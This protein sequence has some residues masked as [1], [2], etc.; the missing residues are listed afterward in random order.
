MA[1]RGLD[2]G[3][4]FK[5]N[6]QSALNIANPSQSNLQASPQAQAQIQKLIAQVQSGVPIQQIAAN[7]ASAIASALAPSATN[8]VNGLNNGTTVDPSQVQAKITDLITNALAPPGNSPPGTPAQQVAALVMKVQNWLNDIAGGA[9]QGT[10]QQSEFSEQLLDALTAKD[11]PAQ[12]NPTQSSSATAAAFART[13]LDSVAS[14]LQSG[15]AQ[16][17][18][19]LPTATGTPGRPGGPVA[20]GTPG[21]K[22]PSANGT[23]G[24]ASQ[25]PDAQ[26]TP[27]TSI[28]GLFAT[29]TP[30]F[31]VGGVAN[32]APGLNTGTFA[33]GTPGLLDPSGLGFA[34]GS[35][36]LAD[37]SLSPAPV[38]ATDLLARIVSR[39]AT[40]DGRLNGAVFQPLSTS[41]SNATTLAS[42]AARL[43]ASIANSVA[44]TQTSS[45]HGGN[46]PSFSGNGNGDR[47]SQSLFASALDGAFNTSLANLSTDATQPNTDAATQQTPVDANAVIEQMLKGIQLR[48]TAQGTSEIRLHLTPGDLGPV[49]MKLTVDGNQISANV[50]AHNAAVKEALVNNQ[51]HLA[52]ALAESGLSLSGFSVDVSG[53]NAGQQQQQQSGSRSFGRRYVVHE[54]AANGNAQD[55]T[56]SR[57]GPPLIPATSLGLFNSLA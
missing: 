52:S 57:F 47:S 9:D 29:G 28:S 30:E 41:T 17:L 21:V 56:S 44:V 35:P 33:T 50:V 4:I 8:F 2:F 37:Q 22:L 38:S 39:A 23:P 7:A 14:L 46:T 19:T 10:G 24:V 32:G 18:S 15:P 3:G 26:G 45:S 1:S 16:L 53:G 40:V 43:A 34:S 49:S 54:L 20:S 36:G 12:Q 55:A 6:L 13:L 42:S 11:S 5:S 27:G 25:L 48:T 51:Q 31:N